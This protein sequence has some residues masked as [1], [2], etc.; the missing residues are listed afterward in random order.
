MSNP[1]I[2]LMLENQICQMRKCIYK[3]LKRFGSLQ[4]WFSAVPTGRSLLYKPGFLALKEGSEELR[5][6]AQK[7]P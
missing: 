2:G 5:A 1:D 3:F 7:R 6:Q 4:K